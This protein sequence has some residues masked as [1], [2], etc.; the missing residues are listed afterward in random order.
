MERRARTPESCDLKT[1]SLLIAVG[2][3]NLLNQTDIAAADRSQ[4]KLLIGSLTLVQ[5]IPIDRLYQ[6]T[7]KFLKTGDD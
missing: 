5:F 7:K 3:V 2:V 4:L 6:Q 1:A